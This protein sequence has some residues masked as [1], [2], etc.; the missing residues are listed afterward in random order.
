VEGAHRRRPGEQIGANG[1]ERPTTEKKRDKKPLHKNPHFKG[2]ENHFPSQVVRGKK[3]ATGFEGRGKKKKKMTYKQGGKKASMPWS[4]RGPK[5]K[6]ELKEVNGG[7]KTTLS[8]KNPSKWKNRKATVKKQNR[9]R[10]TEF[11]KKK[12]QEQCPMGN[13]RKGQHVSESER[14]EH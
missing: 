14:K 6:R 13:P 7:G 12:K 1:W 10:A 9:I 8:L 11:G 3:K 4:D 2:N 5:K